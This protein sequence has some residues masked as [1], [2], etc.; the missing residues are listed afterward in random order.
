MEDIRN[1][2]L[3]HLQGRVTDIAYELTRVRFSFSHG[4][5]PWHPAINA[6]RCQDCIL[7]AAELAGVDRSEISIAVEPRRVW[8]RGRRLPPEPSESDGPALHVLAMEI[9]HGAFEREIMLP[10]EVEPELV[11]AEASAVPERIGVYDSRVIAY[12]HFWSDGHQRKLNEL[13]K[14]AK[15]ARA[16]GQVER[17]KEL[18]AV[19]KKEQETSHLQVFSTA[20]VDDVLAGMA[21]RVSMVQKEA[22]VAMLVSKWDEPA[23]KKHRGAK[24]VDVTDLLLREFKL[25]EK[26]MKVAQDIKKQ[27]PLPLEKARKMMREG[28]L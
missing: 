14:A 16:G 5:E 2:Y 12:A 18:D 8:L 9:D 26:K 27:K 4:T 28:K 25:D 21:D 11:E 1:I 3:R 13:I 15:E 20:P 22:D 17:F 24:H 7:I 19:L 6:Y 10:V 23:L